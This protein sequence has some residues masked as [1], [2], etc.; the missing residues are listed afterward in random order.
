MYPQFL[1]SDFVPSTPT[2]GFLLS[3]TPL[4]HGFIVCI[5]LL[6]S[7]QP[8]FF[9]C[10]Y[11]PVLSFFPIHFFL[12]PVT[13]RLTY[14]LLLLVQFF[15]SLL[16]FLFIIFISPSFIL[17]SLSCIF[18][19]IIRVHNFNSCSPFLSSPTSHVQLLTVTHV[20]FFFWVPV[21]CNLSRAHI[22]PF[23]CIFV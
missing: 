18:Q 8:H 11:P 10:F 14:F 3:F 12:I 2:N 7:Y 6:Y 9:P 21:Y 1:Y 16:P 23:V 20:D 22:L 17:L 19:S 5:P 4:V 13:Y 15:S